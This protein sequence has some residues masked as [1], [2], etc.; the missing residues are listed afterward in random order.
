MNA[1]LHAEVAP[2]ALLWL[3]HVLLSEPAAMERLRPHHGKR[4]AVVAQGLPALFSVLGPWPEWHCR[5]TPAGLFEADG[6]EVAVKVLRPG[7]LG[8]IE[9]DLELL[10]T[11][12]GWVERLSADGRRL[13]PREVVAEFD[14]HLHDE[15]DLVREAANAA[16]LR[17]NMQGLN[18]VLVPEMIW[19][20]CRESVL[21]MQRMHGVPISQ[22]DRLRGAGVDI[23]KLARDGVTIFF[24]QVFRDG[25]FHADMHPGNI[26]V[27][28]DAASFGRYIA[29]DF[30]IMGTLTERDKEYLAQN[31]L[32]FFRRDYKRVAELHVESGWVPANTRVDALE[33]AVRAVHSFQSHSFLESFVLI[34]SVV[35]YLAVTIVIG[36]LAARRVHNAK[37]YVVAGRSLPLYMN[38]ATVFA[39]WFGAETVLSVSAT[40]AKDGL[41][42]IPGDPF[43]A[44]VC[45]VLAAL[46]FA[47]LFYRMNLLTIGDFY[48]ARYGK[49]VE[50][51]TSLA[52]VLSYL[53]WTSAQMT[54]LGLVIHTLSGGALALNQ[55]ILIGAGVVLVYTLFGGMWSVAF[56]DLFQTVVILV[57][58][59]LVAVLVGDLAGGPAKVI[60]Q[61]QAEGKFNFF[62]GDTAGWWAMAGAFFAFAF[63]SIPQQDVFQR[64]TSAKDEKTAVR[65]TLL[66]ALIYFCFAF[67][68]IYIA[69]AAMVA[70]PGL[71]KLFADEDARVIQ[72][73]LPDLVL[74]KM[75]LWA[76]VMFFGALLSAILSTA[77]GALLAP[78]ALFT[79][80]VLRPFVPHMGDRQFLLTLRI[81]LVTFTAAAL[82]FAMNSKSTMYE[83][84][85][86]A[87]NVTLTGAFVPLVAGAY[88]KRAN[89]QGALLSI[90]LGIG[91]WL[92]ASQVAAEAL[93]PAMVPANLLGL[94][95]S[96]VGMVIGTLLPA[97]LPHRGQAIE[98]TL[99]HAHQQL[100]KQAGSHGHSQRH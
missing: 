57:G 81:I 89:T 43:G 86:N 54:A 55:A 25:F 72:R 93:V 21:V 38:V 92:L 42:G 17:R 60:A 10:H 66:G 97:V 15:L 13:K 20:Y 23:A 8:V 82:L 14:A 34:T 45:L 9:S 40:F 100:E 5:I 31:F 49:G 16:Q 70:D 76:Q 69:Y 99:K 94:F 44:T 77:S 29:L 39:T 32:A 47:R 79:E 71:A 78:T 90:V 61:A 59:T 33:S 4:I 37:D 63:G 11:L 30:G 7:M 28:L 18:L 62:P 48:K 12:A 85:Q 22:L 75:P 27:S 56:T 46:L 95:A 73:V 50:V 65:G 84:V 19:D 26:Q 6:R 53:G 67:V 58:L 91:T 41:R 35:L 80:N 1:R 68:P 36:L 52:I 2:R 88:W 64:M 87:Y 96:V 74:G 51:L 24:T 83:M 3:N 98:T